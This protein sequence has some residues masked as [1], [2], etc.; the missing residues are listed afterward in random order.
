MTEKRPSYHVAWLH[1]GHTKREKAVRLSGEAPETA[2]EILKEAVD[3]LKKATEHIDREFQAS[4]FYELSKTY[5]RL[6]DLAEASVKA[7][8]A[9]ERSS[10]PKYQTW[11]EYIQHKLHVIDQ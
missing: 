2:T 9:C 10:D 11:L 4:A 8:E 5:F 6:N 3:A 7:Q 1:L